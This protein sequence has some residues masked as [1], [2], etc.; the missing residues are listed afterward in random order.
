[1]NLIERYLTVWVFL[2]IVVGIALGNLMPGVF[3]LIGDAE[4]VRVNIPVAVLI[5]LMV[6]PTLLLIDAEGN[7]VA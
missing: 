5:W 7:R 3:Q 1:M 4:L 2:C 6:I